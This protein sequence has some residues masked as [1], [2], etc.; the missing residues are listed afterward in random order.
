M[1]LLVAALTASLFA[2][3]LSAG[4]RDA[5]IAA[6]RAAKLEAWPRFYREQDWQGLQAFLA[7]GF[8]AVQPDGSVE[9]REQAVAWVRDNAW[10]NV[11]NNFVYTIRS[12]DF[13]GPDVANVHGTGRFNT[14]E[15]R[16][17]YQSANIFVREGGRWRAKFSQ[18]TD[19]TCEA[20]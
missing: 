19:S 4:D 13:Y 5:D 18:T 17:A 11:D 8:V 20:A 7:D 6:L 12:I 16:K 15:C 9:T 2:T 1:R 14:T 10:A 3:P